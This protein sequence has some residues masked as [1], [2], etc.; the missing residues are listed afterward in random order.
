MLDLRFETHSTQNFARI[1]IEILS[2][3]SLV[4]TFFTKNF[5]E[6]PRI[7]ERL[8]NLYRKARKLILRI[9]SDAKNIE[10]FVR[11]L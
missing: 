4:T 2:L 11:S 8:L 6:I 1:F 9:T 7:R 10:A 3:S 5:A